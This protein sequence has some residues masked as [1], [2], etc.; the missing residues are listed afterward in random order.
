MKKRNKIIYWIAT[1]WL[2]LGM[3]S[4][5]IVQLMKMKEEQME[6]AVKALDFESAALIRDE[7]FKLEEKMGVGR[8]RKKK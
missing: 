8:V 6:E 4:T 2:C 3:T 7:I 1:I 5:A